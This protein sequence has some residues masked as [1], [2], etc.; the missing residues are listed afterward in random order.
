[1][2]N[3]WRNQTLL[4]RIILSFLLLAILGLVIAIAVVSSR[5]NEPTDT[6]S[7]DELNSYI[8]KVKNNVPYTVEQDLQTVVDLY[9]TKIDSAKDLDTKNELMKARIDFLTAYD[10]NNLFKNIAINDAKFIDDNQSTLNSC[11]QV[12]N[13]AVKYDDQTIVEEYQQILDKRALDNG[14]TPTN[15]GSG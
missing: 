13:T 11:V 5:P 14:L 8:E 12:I 6:N 9:Q 3:W 2:N 15:E 10:T 4:L 1:M 7:D